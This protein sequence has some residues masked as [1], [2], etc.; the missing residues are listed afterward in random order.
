[1]SIHDRLL[2]A[3]GTSHDSYT[4]ISNAQMTS[5]AVRYAS[6]QSVDFLQHN[7][8]PQDRL[9]LLKDPRICRL[10]PVWL[11]ASAKAGVKPAFIMPVRHPLKVAQSLLRRNGYHINK[12]LLMWLRHVLTAER[13]TRGHARSFVAYDVLMSDWT[14]VAARIAA[15]LQLPWPRAPIL[16]APE[17]AEF[18]DAGLR[19][20]TLD[21]H[22]A[23][24]LA[25]WVRD[26]WSEIENLLAVGRCDTDRLYPISEEMRQ[27]ELIFAPKSGEEAPYYQIASSWKNVL[28]HNITINPVKR[29]V[30][31]YSVDE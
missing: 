5:D 8:A 15:D 6:A 13:A 23:D 21:R 16:A 24:G 3:L 2:V 22:A 25:P 12:G 17:I 27:A 1:M 20:H 4:E 10:V 18:L 26:C 14:G 30:G 19:H 9:L 28:Q 29:D 31:R 11:E 7:F